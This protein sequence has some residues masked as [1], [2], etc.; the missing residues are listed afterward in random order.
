MATN[1][2]TIY[3]GLDYSEF[4]GGVTEI[5]RKMGLLDAE[6]KLAKEQAKAYGTETDELGLKHE[7]LTQKIELQ[8]KKVEEAKKAYD[9]AM[10]SNTAS[11][12]EIDKLDLK[13]LQERT[14]L[15]QLNSELNDN[16]K[17]TDKAT[18]ANKSFGDEIRGVADTLGI[19]VSPAIEKLAKK[20]DGV[21]AAVGNAILGIGAMISGLVKCSMASAE[22]ADE[23]ITLSNQTGISTDELQKMQYA[24]KFLDVDVQTM[25][26]SINKMVRSM[27]EA[28]DGSGNASEAFKKLRI[29]VT[30]SRGA[31]RDQNDVFAEVID[32]LKNV[33]NE[34]ERDALSMQI[35]GRS[36]QEL[37]PL[38]KA[39]SE[40]LKEYYEE[41]EKLGIVMSEEDV[42]ALGQMQ[43]AWD[44]MQSSFDAVK[45]QLALALLPV[46]TKLFEV[47][48]SI[49][50]PVLSTLVTL[51][52]I[53]ATIVLVVKAIKSMTGTA[54][55][56]G[57]F[58]G[59]F[60]AK[61]AKTTLVIVGIVVALIA[62]AAIIAVIIGKSDELNNTMENIGNSTKAVSESVTG[63]QE[64]VMRTQSH[65]TGTDFFSGGRTWVGEAGPEL[66]T[67]PR[68]SKITPEKDVPGNVT[69]IFNITIDA[70]NVRDFNRVVELAEAQQMATRRV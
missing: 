45:N 36:A 66:V 47:I 28:R 2:R 8:N 44:K 69:K 32:K 14:K 42:M 35:F 38:I 52:G 53:I 5:N 27:N 30:D 46:L 10:S 48:S 43:D 64:N 11:Q 68:G 51:A 20:F 63:A 50:A 6:F 4:S 62:L 60:S 54:K 70:K 1:K 55:A 12:K 41:A 29:R 58:F 37:N 33:K 67:L 16:K 21:S 18:G 57:D 13:L 56:I 34:T 7:Y 61:G 23:L 65:A 3:L 9:A 22:L 24:S 40:G 31:L 25:T 17:A 15:E 39:G 19:N 49:P 26:G 59:T